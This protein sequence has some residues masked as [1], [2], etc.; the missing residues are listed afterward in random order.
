MGYQSLIFFVKELPCVCVSSYSEFKRLLTA[1][2]I[3]GLMTARLGH[4]S[5]L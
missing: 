2:I 1:C 3:M 4:T 5:Y